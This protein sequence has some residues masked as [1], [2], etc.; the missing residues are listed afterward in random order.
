MPLDFGTPLNRLKGWITV[1]GSSRAASIELEIAGRIGREIA[2][3]G[4]GLISGGRGGVMEAVARAHSEERGLSIGILPG[5][6]YSQAN[7][8]NSIN[9]PSGI[10]YARNLPNILAGRGVVVVGGGPG[11]LTELGYALQYLRPLFIPTFLPGVAS[12]AEQIIGTIKPQC[13]AIF[14]D[15][16]EGLIAL[17][18]EW[19]RDLEK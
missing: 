12:I 17:F 18:Q 2:I 11:T 13:R 19:L 7:P 1:I 9:L 16:E 10:G 4:W 3:Q 6:D 15:R 5:D 8:H 14:A